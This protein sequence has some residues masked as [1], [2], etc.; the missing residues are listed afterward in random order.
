MTPK[1]SGVCLRRRHLNSV[2]VTLGFSLHE[3][4]LPLPDAGGFGSGYPFANDPEF[5][6]WV[7][8]NDCSNWQIVSAVNKMTCTQ[9]T[10]WC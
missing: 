9:A 5:F 1:L 10:Y 7:G 2:S 6:F 4:T 8:I 3:V